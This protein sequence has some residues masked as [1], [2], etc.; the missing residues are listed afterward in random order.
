M[1]VLTIK[2]KSATYRELFALEKRDV[3]KSYDRRELNMIVCA[4]SEKAIKEIYVYHFGWVF[5]E[6]HKS[7]GI[8][9]HEAF[10]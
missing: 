10:V 6:R 4:R 1:Y 7:I 9:S 3:S 8:A 5:G 2:G